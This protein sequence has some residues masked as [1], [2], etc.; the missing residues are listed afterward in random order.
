MGA[1]GG[2]QPVGD[3]P[4]GCELTTYLEIRDVAEESLQGHSTTVDEMMRAA[5]PAG[6]FRHVT[7]VNESLGQYVQRKTAGASEAEL[8]SYVKQRSTAICQQEPDATR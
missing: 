5:R 2:G 3:A 4:S 1:A 6:T 8:N 7:L